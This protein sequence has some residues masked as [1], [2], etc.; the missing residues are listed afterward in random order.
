MT[1]EPVEALVAVAER[2][3][4][5]VP[6]A[7]DL[8][9]TVIT[10]NSRLV[11]LAGP[12]FAI[13]SL[14]LV[15]WIVFIAM[16][17]PSRQLSSHYDVAWAGFDVF[18]FVGLAATAFFALRRSRWLPIAAAA[19][20]SMLIIDAWFD[21]L[22]SHAGRDLVVAVVFALLVELPLSALCWF[23]AH[24]GEQFS[25][26]RLEAVLA[27]RAAHPRGQGQPLWRGAA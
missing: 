15:P 23:V 7:D 3:D 17:L 12:L 10:D 22:T 27:Y 2:V 4:R 1:N 19:T 5:S 16:A 26:K 14:L 11:R 20:A 9:N 24:Q 18:L 21:V 13:L 6:V 8:G 25:E